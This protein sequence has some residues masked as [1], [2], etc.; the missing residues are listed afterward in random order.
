[1]L[2]NRIEKAMMNNP[3]RAAVQRHV[4]ARVLLAMGGPMR[5]GTALEVGC[6]RGLGVGVILDQFG[7][8]RVDAFDLDPHMVDLARRRLARRGDRVRLWAGDVSRIAAEDNSYDAVFDFGIIHHVPMW[9]DALLEVRRV[10]KPGGR[11]YAEE[12]LA[13]FIL[14]PVWRRL[15]DHPLEDRFDRDAF[16]SAL[17]AAGFEVI[18]KR[19]LLGDFAWFIADKPVR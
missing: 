17:G 3:V 18:A 12:V 10:L 5:G 9:R 15:L 16:Q 4:E 1:M 2:L 6:G 7:A 14:N 19:S 8:D 11:F 13:H